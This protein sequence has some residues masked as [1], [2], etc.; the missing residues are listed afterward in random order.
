MRQ[1]KR[2]LNTILS[3]K[4]ALGEI[5]EMTAKMVKGYDVLQNLDEVEI[6]T[7]PKKLVYQDGKLRLFQYVRETEA[8]CKTPVLLVYALVNRIEML[9]LQ[10]D[11]S[12][13]RNLLAQ[14]LDVYI[15]DWGYPDRSD[16]YFTM[17]DYVNRFIGG[18]VDYVRKASNK[19]KINIASVCQG[20]TLSTI[21]TA[22]NPDKVKNLITV[23]A[24]IDFAPND[25]LLFRWAKHL[26]FDTIVD[27]YGTVPGEFL[28]AGF[29][30]LR[31]FQKIDKYVSFMN[32]A[33][34]E[35]KM[36]NFLRMEKWIIDSPNQAGE[37]YRQ[38]MKDLYQ[39][40]KLV[41][42]EL[43]VGDRTVNLKNVTC[44]VFNIYAG[45]DHIVP[46]ATS[47]P[48]NELVGT[49]DTRMMEVPGGHI[50]IFV[51]SRAQKELAPG[52]STWLHERDA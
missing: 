14:G 20:G 11:R 35:D 48:L 2:I 16:R 13:V 1:E 36:L 8:T 23:A 4:S 17:A 24:P 45:A 31:P 15:I 34:D 12:L 27:T 44:P 32:M 3:A 25:G 51:G 38:F 9:D 28:N 43:V 30:Q 39:Q 5:E 47:I 42:G 7:A 52:I 46:P 26:N 29:S 41:K 18:C 37:C 22:L 19:E 21:Y 40:N 50:G 10:P 49:K 6:G 33:G